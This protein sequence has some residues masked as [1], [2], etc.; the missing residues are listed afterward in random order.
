MAGG[1]ARRRSPRFA[2]DALHPRRHSAVRDRACVP[3]RGAS[4]RGWPTRRALACRCRRQAGPSNRVG[5]RNASVQLVGRGG[6]AARSDS[7][8]ACHSRRRLARLDSAGRDDLGIFSICHLV[9]SRAGL[10]ILRALAVFPRGVAGAELSW[11]RCAGRGF[12]WL[13]ALR[14]AGAPRPELVTLE[15][16]R[17]CAPGNRRPAHR[18]S[19][20]EQRRRVRLARRN[21][22]ACG[23]SE[24]SHRGRVRIR[25]SPVATRRTV[26]RG[27]SA[28]SL[29]DL[30]LSDWPAVPDSGRSRSA[31]QPPHRPLGKQ[32]SARRDMGLRPNS[33]TAFSVFSYSRQCGGLSSSAWR[34]RCVG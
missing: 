12:C 26:A 28:P 17:A 31:D 15:S 32:S 18:P 11:R 9:Q 4:R 1:H 8:S 2:T 20:A 27:L 30:G 23:N 10:R 24:R 33:S 3:G 5:R 21:G 14:D 7:G 25:H 34:S 29:G 6:S 13:S 16:D 19:H 22:D